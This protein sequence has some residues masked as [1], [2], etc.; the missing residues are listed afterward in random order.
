[1]QNDIFANTETILDL[2]N[3][4]TERPDELEKDD[5]HFQLMVEYEAAFDPNLISD[6]DDYLSGSM[7]PVKPRSRGMSGF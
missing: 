1:M 5:D 6:A 7:S 3:L 2:N 4:E